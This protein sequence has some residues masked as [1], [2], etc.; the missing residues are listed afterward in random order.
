MLDSGLW[1]ALR[2]LIIGTVALVVM[3]SRWTGLIGQ[4]RPR[5]LITSI[6]AELA[7]A[8]ELDLVA[9]RDVAKHFLDKSLYAI[10]LC[11]QYSP[12]PDTSLLF[13]IEGHGEK[14]KSR[15]KATFIHKV[16]THKIVFNILIKDSIVRYY[17]LSLVHQIF[18]F[19]MGVNSVSIRTVFYK[20]GWYFNI[21][22]M[23][24]CSWFL[25]PSF[26][27]SPVSVWR[28]LKS[29]SFCISIFSSDGLFLNKFFNILSSETA[30]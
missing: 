28:S 30:S 16:F 24:Y 12:T 19:S 6:K 14:E 3:L 15:S 26:M 7:N 2:F 23:F 20:E 22:L 17:H 21:L 11:S 1:T 25:S 27:F 10:G 8:D 13:S 5:K 29:T 9:L 18:R 4:F